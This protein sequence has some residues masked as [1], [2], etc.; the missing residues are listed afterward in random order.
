MDF[1]QFWQIVH[2]FASLRSPSLA[3][4]WPA[5]PLGTQWRALSALDPRFG[6]VEIVGLTRGLFARRV[7]TFWWEHGRSD[8]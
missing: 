1:P 5:V 2:P 8:G 6:R 7:S 3:T 4:L